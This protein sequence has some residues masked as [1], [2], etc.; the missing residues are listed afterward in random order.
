MEGERDTWHLTR[1][2][3]GR[4]TDGSRERAEEGTEKK[5]YGGMI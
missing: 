2:T 1:H 3:H 5:E 4:C